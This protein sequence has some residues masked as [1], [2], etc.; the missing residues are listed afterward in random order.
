MRA[1]R[2]GHSRRASPLSLRHRV[3]L[4]Y[5]GRR[6][7]LLQAP[8]EAMRRFG[9][10]PV[11]DDQSRYTRSWVGDEIVIEAGFANTFRVFGVLIDTLWTGRRGKPS[12]GESVLEYRFGRRRRFVPRRGGESARVLAEKLSDDPEIR[13][14]IDKA[15]LKTIRVEDSTHGRRVQIRPMA[16]TITALYFPPLPPY[17]V[18]VHDDE[19]DAQLRLLTRLLVL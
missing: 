16:G 10:T 2:G 15:E 11:M 14:L 18:A 4:L 19:A 9:L 3:S 5:S 17:T 6:A 12:Q 7:S 1:K 13:Q 8:V